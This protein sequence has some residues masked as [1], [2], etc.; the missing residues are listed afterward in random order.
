[1]ASFLCYESIKSGTVL[2]RFIVK[3]PYANS[4]EIAQVPLAI[5]VSF[6]YNRGRQVLFL[7][8][9]RSNHNNTAIKGDSK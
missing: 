8:F 9:I 1:M 7:I 3:S 4:S 2:F 6:V 5:L